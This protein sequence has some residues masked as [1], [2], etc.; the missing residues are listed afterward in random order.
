MKLPDFFASIELNSVKRRMGIPRD[1]YGNLFAKVDPGRLTEDEIERLVSPDGLDIESGDLTVLNDH[2]LAFKGR[3]VLLYIRDVPIYGNQRDVSPKFHIANC[4]TLV[5]MKEQNR[6]NRYVVSQ[7]TSGVFLVHVIEKTVVDKRKMRLLVCQNCLSKLAFEGF[8]DT[9]GGPERKARVS[10]FTLDK[11]FTTYPRSLHPKNPQFNSDNAPL[12]TYTEDWAK[13]SAAAKAAAMWRCQ[14]PACRIDLSAPDKR[15]FL[16]VH[17]LDGLKFNNSPSN[18][19]V[20]CLGCHAE[21]TAH[22]HM[23]NTAE[24]Q[25][26]MVIRRRQREQ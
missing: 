4:R 19:R 26:F 11:F 9:L 2:T 14:Q 6:F 20:E 7:N 12:N 22:E 25:Q 13:V 24:Y 10:A 3:R 21:E 17:H 18:L 8:D 16:H 5:Q 23:K 1:V 15:R